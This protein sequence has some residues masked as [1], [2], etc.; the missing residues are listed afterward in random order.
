M[1][2]TL[3]M[4]VHMHWGYA[5][6]YAARTWSLEDWRGYATGL[7]ELGYDFVMIWPMADN[8]PDPLTPSDISHLTKLQR[9]IEMLRAELG[10][11]VII[12]FGANSVG[13]RAAGDYPFEERPYFLTENRLDPGDAGQMNRLIKFRSKVW[14][15]L[16]GADGIVIIDSDPGGYI[17]STNEQFAS[18]LIR[19]M[20]MLT[21]AGS[22][23]LLFYWM[24][25]GWE[26]YSRFWQQA[27]ETASPHIAEDPKDWETVIAELQRNDNGR[28]RFLVCSGAHRKTAKRM[29]I[30]DRSV[31]YPYGAVEG[32]P[33]F[34]L[35][36]FTPDSI[37]ATLAGFPWSR[38][39]LGCMAN[40]QSHVLQLPNTWFFSR[41]TQSGECDVDD[42]RPFASQLIPEA[43]DWLVDAWSAISGTDEQRARELAACAPPVN[44]GSAGPLSGLMIGGPDRFVSDLKMQLQFRAEMLRLAKCESPA[45]DE[46]KSCVRALLSAWEPWIERTGFVDAYFGPVADAIHPALRRL[47]IPEIDCVLDDFDNWRTPEVRNG[48]VRRLIAALRSWSSG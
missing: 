10:M 43:A 16:S 48:V 13:N 19:H 22:E 32:E 5:W 20:D 1:P 29:G 30:E 18:L 36:N 25:V 47:G 14:D 40:A 33:T 2:F 23:A 6:P 45:D 39:Y 12:T 7:R 15:Y 11:H 9:V 3:G 34:P 27:Q 46:G 8:M 41:A 38:P 31:F 17:G 21:A 35:T 37:A 24:W 28:W 26:G 44:G 4:Y 42:L